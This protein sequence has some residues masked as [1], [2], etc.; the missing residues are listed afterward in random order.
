MEDKL[1]A[2]YKI[3]LELA[4]NSQ[5]P[6][7]AVFDFDNTCIINDIGDA[8]IDYLARNNPNRYQPILEKIYALLGKG[9]LQ[10][11]YEFISETLSGF[12]VN[13]VT[14]LVEEVLK[15]EGKN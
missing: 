7:F 10:E 6:I 8:T 9:K 5:E 1:E 2:I 11:S 14:L 15:T 3:I 12:S 13:E 4:K